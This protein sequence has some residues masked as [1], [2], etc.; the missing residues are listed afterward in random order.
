MSRDFQEAFGRTDF[1]LGG[2]HLV[3]ASAGTGKTWNIGNI[4]ARLL[5]ANG[6]RIPQILVVTFTDAATHE[7]RERLRR[8][9]Q[10]LQA[11]FRNPGSGSCRRDG[12]PGRRGEPYRS[13]R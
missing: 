1:P 9:L 6:W 5:M 8:L 11:E 10:E 7:L 2:V 13:F 12:F 4:F 3:A